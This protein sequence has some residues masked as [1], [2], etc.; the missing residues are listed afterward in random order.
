MRRTQPGRLSSRE[1]AA[2]P[3]TE[4][5]HD[6]LLAS[7]GEITLDRFAERDE[8][9]HRLG[10]VVGTSHQLGETSSHR[11][12]GPGED[13]ASFGG[14]LEADSPLIAGDVLAAQQALRDERADSSTDGRLSEREAFREPG[15]P[16]VATGDER[17][18][19]VVG[20]AELLSGLVEYPREPCGSQHRHLG[21]WRPCGS[22]KGAHLAKTSKM[23]RLSNHL[24][25]A[26]HMPAN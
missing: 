13:L 19:A 16:L 6:P 2:G 18:E 8:G 22:F 23:V 21:A 7:L 17:Q 4:L 12:L 1:A 3:G 20:E 9:P 11:G 15:G 5:T 25:R 14:E 10:G 24:R 26:N